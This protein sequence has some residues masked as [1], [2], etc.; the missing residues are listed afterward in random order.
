MSPT[1]NPK[2]SR[3][4]NHIRP[5]HFR[6][7]SLLD[8]VTPSDMASQPRGRIW[9]SELTWAR[10]RGGRNLTEYLT[11]RCIAFRRREFAL[12]RL[13][14]GSVDLVC[15]SKRDYR[16]LTKPTAPADPEIQPTNIIRLTFHNYEVAELECEDHDNFSQQQRFAYRGTRYR[17]RAVARDDRGTAAQRSTFYLVRDGQQNDPIACIDLKLRSPREEA[18]ERRAGFWVPPCFMQITDLETL[19]NGELA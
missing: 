18:A 11:C 15:I 7:C 6:P 3:K 2:R 1:P 4:R 10:P 13:C 17:W 12:C 14:S 5:G 8:C 19:G 16:V 9:P